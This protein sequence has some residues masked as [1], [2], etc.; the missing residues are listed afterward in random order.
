MSVEFLD[1]EM[2]LPHAGPTVVVTHHAPH[3]RSLMAPMD[4]LNPCYASDLTWMVAKHAPVLWVHGHCHVPSDYTVEGTRIIANPRGY[5]GEI[6]HRR[7]RQD[8]VVEV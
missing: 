7:W 8:L 6:S 1:I 2:S 3:P 5:P 4:S